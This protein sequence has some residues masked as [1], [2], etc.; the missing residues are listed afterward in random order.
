MHPIKE[1]ILWIGI[2]L[3][4]LLITLSGCQPMIKDADHEV[5]LIEWYKKDRSMESARDACSGVVDNAIGCA[6][7]HYDKLAEVQRCRI[8]A[9]DYDSLYSLESDIFIHEITHCFRGRFHEQ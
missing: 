1:N 4:I 8:F 6:R 5:V 9:P 7:S 3:I 2:F